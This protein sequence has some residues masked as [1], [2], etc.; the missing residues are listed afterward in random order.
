MVKLGNKITVQ[1]RVWFYKVGTV[2]HALELWEENEK[3]RT[4]AIDVGSG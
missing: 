1:F 3:E 2:F 4:L